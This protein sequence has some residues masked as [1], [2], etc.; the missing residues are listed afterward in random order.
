MPGCCCPVFLPSLSDCGKHTTVMSF[1][2]LPSCNGQTLIENIEYTVFPTSHISNYQHH[3][4][5]FILVYHTQCS[6]LAYETT[7]L[8]PPHF[9]LMT[10]RCSPGNTIYVLIF[11]E[12]PQR[13]FY[14][15]CSYNASTL[16]RTY[17]HYSLPHI[18]ILSQ[19][20]NSFQTKDHNESN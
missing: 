11:Q 6:L 19:K 2:Q 5:F 3:V 18:K 10:F 4:V 16:F 1:E 17:L 14:S 9:T 8:Q 13:L 7:H 12:A 15:S 20:T